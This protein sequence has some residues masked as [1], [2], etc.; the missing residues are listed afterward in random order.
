MRQT[1]DSP[2]AITGAKDGLNTEAAYDNDRGIHVGAIVSGPGISRD[3][4]AQEGVD[5]A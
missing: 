4:T 3:A 5:A 1:R 2:R